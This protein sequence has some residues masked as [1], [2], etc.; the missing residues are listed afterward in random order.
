MM[1]EK[2]EK[3]PLLEVCD[4]SVSFSMYSRG[5]QK[6]NLEVLLKLSLCVHP[7]EIFAVVG[8]SG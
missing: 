2:Q 3:E 1:K 6:R 4:L 5:L 7:G 8:S